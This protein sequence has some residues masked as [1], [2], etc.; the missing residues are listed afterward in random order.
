M[1]EAHFGSSTEEKRDNIQAV[2]H[3]GMLAFADNAK[4]RF[5]QRPYGPGGAKYQG[6]DP[7]AKPVLQLRVRQ[8]P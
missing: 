4:S 7:W 6:L 2:G 3:D 5:L 1:P 8:R